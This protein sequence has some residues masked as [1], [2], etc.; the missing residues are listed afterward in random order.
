MKPIEAANKLCPIQKTYGKVRETAIDEGE[1]E[2][3]IEYRPHMH[4]CRQARCM[5]W[6]WT[7]AEHTDGYCGLAGKEGAE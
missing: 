1:E 5:M 6:R 4:N 2:E 7:N 3:V